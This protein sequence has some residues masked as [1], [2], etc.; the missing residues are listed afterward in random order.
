[1]TR[2]TTETES[3]FARPVGAV[4]AVEREPEAAVS[5][6]V[7]IERLRAAGVDAD[8]LAPDV[9][10]ALFDRAAEAATAALGLVFAETGSV[11][12]RIGLHAERLLLDGIDERGRRA[13]G[14]ARR[15]ARVAR[16][17]TVAVAA[18]TL[19]SLGRVS[20]ARVETVESDEPGDAP[21]LLV[22]DRALARR[23][24]LVLRAMVLAGIGA[25]GASAWRWTEGRSS[26][27][28]L[29]VGPF[30]I[31]GADA[32]IAWVGPMLRDGLN[33]RL[34]GLSQAKV[35][36]QEFLDFLM[37]RERLG[38]IEVAARL[39][40]E[41]M[42]TGHVVVLDDVIRVET[43]V[44][45][46]ESGLLDGVAMVT[47]GRR[48]LLSLEGRLVSEVI[49]HLRLPLSPADERRLAAG[50][51]SS[52]DALRRLRAV[53]GGE[54]P[55]ADGG[56]DV[57][58]PIPDPGDRGWLLERFGPR[59]ALAEGPSASVPAF[60]QEYRRVLE[61]RD[62]D[63]LAQFYVAVSAEQRQAVEEYFANARELRVRIDAV[64]SAV[65]GDDAV[66]TYTRTDEFV[67]AQTG[68]P[69]HASTR[70]TKRLQRFGG[71]WRFAPGK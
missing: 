26:E 47:G 5:S 9:V 27:V 13:I 2:E 56:G 46:V 37:E 17:G 3:S 10:V 39:G 24:R 65:V 32:T 44:V 14:E 66:V 67:D 25:L 19:A 59:A 41:K 35:Y 61:A 16:P 52:P 6:D 7:V 18:A 38:P 1:V 48:E 68:H 54:A 70:V 21:R 55:A 8:L 64:E 71:R 51:A 20:S 22:P 60:L 40:I 30:R 34:S 50:R 33:M 23:R 53:E 28:V 31:S 36:S 45:D 69:Q 57:P 42:L 58:V 43:R 12:I 63:A 49:A 11:G 15:L 4:L 29:G 62:S